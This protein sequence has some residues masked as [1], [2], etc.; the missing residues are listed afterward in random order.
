[1]LPGMNR[2]LPKKKRLDHKHREHQI[3]RIAAGGSSR[4]NCTRKGAKDKFRNDGTKVRNRKGVS[5][6]DSSGDREKTR[7]QR[8]KTHPNTK[9]T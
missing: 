9:R 7:G 8:Q 5:G 3:D 6:V 1:V 4:A 2:V